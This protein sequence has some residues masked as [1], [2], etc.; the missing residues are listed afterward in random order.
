MM[1]LH[2][3]PEENNM[4]QYFKIRNILNIIF[5]IGAVV[6]MGFYFF[7]NRTI[8][9]IIII[10]AIVIKLTESSIRLIHR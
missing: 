5:M 6:G 9:T 8:G 4:D 10:I 1:R 7:G 3:N 2:R